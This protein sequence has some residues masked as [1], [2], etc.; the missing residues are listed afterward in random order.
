MKKL[1]KN[2]IKALCVFVVL[3]AMLYGSFAYGY[4]NGQK[5]TPVIGFTK[6]ANIVNTEVGKPASVDFSLFWDAWNKLKEKSV[7]ATDNQKMLYGAISGMMNSINDPYTVFFTPEDNKRFKEDIGGQFVGI[8]VELVEKSGYPT[9][10]APLSKTPAETAGIKAGD[11][12]LQVDGKKT[13]EMGFNEI[14]DNIRGDKGT[15]VKLQ[16][17]REGSDKPLEISVVRDTIVVKS[18]EWET[19][20]DNGKK[21]DYVKVRQF[22]DDT[23]SLFSD[24]AD[25]VAK[26]KPDG[27]II[28]LRDNPG[29]YLETAVD[30]SSYF[31]DGVV[32][33]EKGKDINKDYS[34]VHSATLKNYKTTILVNGGSASAS[35]IFSG[36]LQDHKAATLIGEQTFGKGCV[37]ELIDLAGGSAIKVTVAN[38]YTPNG[39][40][41]S[42]TGNTPDVVIKNDDNSKVDAQLNRAI[43]FLET[44]K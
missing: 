6:Q 24:F 32:V 14:I 40:G 31:V 17:S 2:W 25:Q 11:I 44:G 16:I 41:I 37:Q 13:S 12:I 1:K 7:A 3:A 34:T 18:V 28:D 19:K 39:R 22:G 29:G 15:T 5:G 8:G 4:S 36:A 26:D 21:Y 27:I 10:V 42:G 35:E 43:N 33:S 9:V 23:S 20:T 30:L 38:W